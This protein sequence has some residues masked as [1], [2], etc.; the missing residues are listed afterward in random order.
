MPDEEM[1]DEGSEEELGWPWE[2]EFDEFD[3]LQAEC[4]WEATFGKDEDA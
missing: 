1:P 3:A 4:E 2:G